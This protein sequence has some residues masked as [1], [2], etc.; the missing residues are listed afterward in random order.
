MF[1][2]GV[3]YLDNSVNKGEKEIKLEQL[4]EINEGEKI[5]LELNDSTKIT[6][7]NK[8]IH[9]FDEVHKQDTKVSILD[10]NNIIKT[11]N[12]SDV[13]KYYYVDEGGN[14]WLAFAI[15]F[16]GMLHPQIKY[17]QESFFVFYLV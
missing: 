13:N 4:A 2:G 8:G 12:T 14:V 17:Y 3:V 9:E 15:L 6:G 5:V 11:I 10:K 16:C 1:L 7:L